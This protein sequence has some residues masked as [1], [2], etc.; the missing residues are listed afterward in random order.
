[1]EGGREREG[2]GESEKIEIFLF[3]YKATNPIE[4]GSH[5]YDFI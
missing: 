3:S 5:P 1:M 4:L 2:E